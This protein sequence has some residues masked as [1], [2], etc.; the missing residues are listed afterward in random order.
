M[1][2]VTNKKS[3]RKLLIFAL[4]FILLTSIYVPYKINA[5]AQYS[6]L[7]SDDF[8]AIVYPNFSGGIYHTSLQIK[9]TS[10]ASEIYYTLNGDDPTIENQK[11]VWPINLDKEG[12]T[13]IKYFAIDSN[14]NT[15][16]IYEDTYLLDFT[17][18]Q[19]TAFPLGG[20]YNH[21]LSLVLS[22]NEDGDI[23]YTLN[24]SDPTTSSLKYT[25]PIVLNEGVTSVKYMAIDQA[26]NKSKIFEQTYDIDLDSTIAIS[27]KSSIDNE[28]FSITLTTTQ[29]GT[30]YYTIDGTNPTTLSNKYLEPIAINNRGVTVLKYMFVNSQGV[31]SEVYTEY[32]L[33][34]DDNP[35]SAFLINGLKGF[36]DWYVSD[37]EID[38]VGAD[39][40]AFAGTYYSLNGAPWKKYDDTLVVGQEGSNTIYFYTVDAAGNK[41]AINKETFQ[42]DKT[43]PEIVIKSPLAGESYDINERLIANWTVSDK[44]S[45]LD[46]AVGTVAS[47]VQLSTATEGEKNFTVYARDEA[48]NYSEV[49]S[50]YYVG[51]VPTDDDDDDDQITENYIEIIPP[52]YLERNNIVKQGSTVPIKFRL[53]SN[54]SYNAEDFALYIAKVENDKVG[55]EIKITSLKKSKTD[56]IFKYDRNEKQY[57]Y[58]LSTKGMSKGLYQIR[59]ELDEHH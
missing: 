35:K 15:S 7:D 9:L 48:G 31:R 25:D 34:D 22:A 4:A 11:Y 18:P 29:R 17:K 10:N 30:I 28:P 58:N 41:K 51:I 21:T 32:Y 45:G 3:L 33:L 53:N 20:E 5:N 12:I 55:N 37:V 6:T 23:Y 50:I 54:N 43:A 26:G 39:N 56:S 36:N 40:L 49:K 59:I 1:Y 19:A 52:L 24:G 16:P 44:Y 13:T 47:G 14:G 42:I 46:Y 38:L 2:H 27:P 8:G 57:S